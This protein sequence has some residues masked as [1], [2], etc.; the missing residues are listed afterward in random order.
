[1]MLVLNW[2]PEEWPNSGANWFVMSENSPTASFGT[3]TSGPVTLLS[4]LSTPS[5]VKLLLLGRWPPTD[6]PVPMPTPPEEATPGLN[7]ETFNTPRPMVGVGR[8]LN[9]S[10]PKVWVRLAVVVSS[11]PPASAE[12]STLLC[13]LDTEREKTA[14]DA[15]FRSMR[16]SLRRKAEKPGAVAVRS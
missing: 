15:L 13:V 1:M 11:A 16:K 4:W 12:T 14:V 6:G 10:V 8:T 2:P 5:M 7:S 9:S 3:Y